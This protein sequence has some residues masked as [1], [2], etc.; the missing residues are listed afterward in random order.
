M[1]VAFQGEPGAYSEQA[2]LEALPDAES[3]PRPQLRDVFETLERG[4]ADLA[5]VPCENSQAGTIHQT[6]DL[7]LEH[8]GRLHITGGGARLEIDGEAVAGGGDGEYPG[9]Y[10]RF[11]DLVRRGESDV[12]LSPFRLVADAFMIGKRIEVE[13]FVE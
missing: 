6:Y 9:L 13:P 1:R 12:D 10:R 4:E 7:L 8:A 5:V 2:L 3:V 11:A